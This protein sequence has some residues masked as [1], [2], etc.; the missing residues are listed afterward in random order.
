MYTHALFPTSS[1]I[2]WS[3]SWRRGSGSKRGWQMAD[4]SAEQEC[5]LA[6]EGLFSRW[7]GRGG[8]DSGTCR[9]Q[10]NGGGTGPES[11][12]TEARLETR[13]P[14]QAAHAFRMD[15]RNRKRE[16]DADRSKGK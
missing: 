13:V 11:S 2:R 7:N 4:G 16:P 15:C 12:P 9:D 1:S 10:G 5:W 3:H 6:A 14:G 8:G